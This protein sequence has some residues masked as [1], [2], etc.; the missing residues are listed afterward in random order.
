[1]LSPESYQD[2]ATGQRYLKPWMRMESPEKYHLAFDALQR[3]GL[4]SVSAAVDLCCAWRECPGKLGLVFRLYDYYWI[5]CTPRGF[6][7]SGAYWQQSK[8][9]SDQE[10]HGYALIGRHEHTEPGDW[11]AGQALGALGLPGEAEPMDEDTPVWI[12]C[13]HG[14]HKHRV[15]ITDVRAFLDKRSSTPYT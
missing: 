6:I 13:P 15:T 7:K 4:T 11:N 1:M 9:A 8:R 5:Y 14:P 10:R 3:L 12:L 2:E